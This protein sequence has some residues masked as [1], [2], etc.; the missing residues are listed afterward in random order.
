MWAENP[1]GPTKSWP[2]ARSPQQTAQER[3]P[4]SGSDGQSLVLLLE[5]A[6]EECALGPGARLSPSGTDSWSV[7]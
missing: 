6:W 2:A 1:A 3:S 7:S 4:R 5:A